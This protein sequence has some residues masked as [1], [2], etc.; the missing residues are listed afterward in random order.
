M[1]VGSL[2]VMEFEP[3]NPLLPHAGVPDAYPNLEPVM[4]RP[5]D[6]DLI[7]QQ[8]DSSGQVCH[9]FEVGDGRNRSHL[10]TIQ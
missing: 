6:W 5:I 1:P 8:Y 4:T 3:N 9:C 7:R 10:E 2:S